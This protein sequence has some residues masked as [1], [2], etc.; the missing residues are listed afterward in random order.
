MGYLIVLFNGMLFRLDGWGKGD[1]F[2]PFKP[3]TLPSWK[4][5]GINYTRYAIGAVIALYLHSWVY[6]ATYAIAA[7]IPYGEKHWWMKFGIVSWFV[8]GA[9]WGGASLSWG[10]ALWMGVIVAIVK[11]MDIDWAW[12]EFGIFGILGSIW[13]LFK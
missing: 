11:I 3:F 4:I 6:L 10:M 13:V 9:I 1:S 2:L 7:S 12:V 8:I 5:G